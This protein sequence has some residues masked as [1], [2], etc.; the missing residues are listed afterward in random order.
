MPKNKT[1]ATT[2]TVI[3]YKGFSK[4]FACR[5]FA[6]EIG[7]T[8]SVDG[9]VR[10]CRNGFHACEYPLSV[11]D[12]Y[13]PA[14]SRSA[15][16]ELSG[17][18]DVEGDKTAARTIKVIKELTHF[19]MIDAAIAYTMKRVTV[20]EGATASG[21]Q[22]AATAS[23]YQGAATASGYQ[24]AATASGY[25]GAATAS[26]DQGAATASGTQGAATAS[27]YQG[28]A[29]ASGLEGRVSGA[30]GNALFAVERGEWDGEGYPILSVACG[31]VGKDGLLPN[32][33]YVAKGGKL[34][35]IV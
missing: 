13:A 3:A 30:D 20:E 21:Y 28:A 22:G 34:V 33:W 12:Y 19:E 6:F 5:E 26:G 32:T 35:E 29:T 18:M 15:L 31:I 16:V 24:G 10:A 23:G 7:Q 4:D 2:E 11:F 27:G 9:N 8:Y 17:D 25:Q 1:A 14:T